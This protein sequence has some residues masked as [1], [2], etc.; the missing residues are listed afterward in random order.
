MKRLSL[1]GL[2]AVLALAAAPVA[3]QRSATVDRDLLRLQDDLI[4]LDD[5]LYELDQIQPA[6]P[7]RGELRDRADRFRERLDRLVADARG[8]SAGTLR[9]ASAD[10]VR[11]L[12]RDIAAL[13][14]DIDAATNRRLGSGVT[15]VLPEG[16]DIQVRLEDSL[17]SSTARQEDRFEATVALPVHDAQGRDVIP[18]GTRVRGIVN[19]VEQGQ[20]PARAGRLEL[21]LDQIY[22]DDRN[23]TAIRSSVVSVDDDLDIKS[24]RT[25]VGAAIGGVLGSILGGTKG[26]IIGAI[27]GG[28]GAVVSKAGEDVSLPAG[29]ILTMRLDRPLDVRR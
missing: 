18:A 20:R 3:A 29:T 2:A 16:T 6:H 22:L 19:R 17:S 9:S 15:S 24:K 23:P 4:N 12:R 7:R 14:R 5:S 8:T 13:Q 28:A 25:G 10:E 1:I 26:A 27:L 21:T 11:S